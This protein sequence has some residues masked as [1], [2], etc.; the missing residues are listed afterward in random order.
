MDAVTDGLIVCDA[1]GRVE[2]LNAAAAKMFGYYPDELMGQKTCRL[3]P[4]LDCKV[5]NEGSGVTAIH[6]DGRAFKVT[7]GIRKRRS[8]TEGIFGAG[9]VVTVRDAL[10]SGQNAPIALGQEVASEQYFQAAVQFANDA[11]ITKNLDGIIVSWNASAERLYGHSAREAIGQHV[12]LIVPERL[13]GE[14]R[15]ELKQLRDGADIRDYETVRLN[16][17]NEEFR[18]SLNVSPIKARDGR[19]IGV[20]SIAREF[21]QRQ[22]AE[23]R[24]MQAIMDTVLDGLV[25]IDETG[26][27]QSFNPAATRLFGYQEAEVIG[28]NV[29]VLMPEPYRSE[30]DNYIASFL[31]TG[32]ARVI[33]IGREV[34]ARR[35]D[36][37]VF[38][39]DLGVAQTTLD[40]RRIFV[41]VLRDISQRKA[42]EER[43]IEQTNRLKAVMNT[44][45][46]GLI[47]IDESGTIRPF[48]PAAAKIFGYA[49]EEVTGRNVNMLMP[50]PY[51]S[52]HDG[53]LRNHLS[54]GRAK[55]IG[56]GREIFGRRKD[57]STFPAE[58]GVNE[59]VIGGQRMFVGTIR[60]ISARKA[61]EAQINDFVEKLQ[62]SNQDLDEFAYIASHDL[63]ELLRGLSNNAVFLEEDYRDRLDEG[64]QKR[65]A[66][67]VYLSDRL[68][69]LVNDLLYY[70]RLGRQDLAIQDTDLNG[71]VQDIE[72]LMAATLV[73]RNVEIKIVGRLPTI[74]CDKTRVTE[75]LRNLIVNAVKYNDKSKKII[76][77]GCREP[78]AR[79]GRGAPIFYVKDNGIGIAE[80]FHEDIFRIFKRLN[81]EDDATKGTGSGLTFVRK[82]VER[83][84]G[85]IWIESVLGD[86]TTFY[87]TLSPPEG[88]DVSE[89]ASP[90]SA[91]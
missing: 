23:A 9:F 25:T 85:R 57:G 41:G 65:L 76:E 48:N 51:H 55:M 67:M 2:G 24:R 53:Y 79:E 69:R 71:V 14:I 35:K 75:L 16:K 5:C 37:S 70:S 47:T 19:V 49:P 11:I 90:Q 31:K 78:V 4:E 30:H 56:I 60:D 73:E 36:G 87:F 17:A 34:M 74:T 91:A 26:T 52:A 88:G 7:V 3:L 68:E 59:T 84:G 39:A 8:R 89:R 46:D 77:I 43:L 32:E 12:D 10:Q 18:I 29:R 66:R 72:A 22:Q 15:R 63:K 20:S 44:V 27:I 6:K 21:A 1:D 64:A 81:V 80:R 83:H 40:G 82:I 42:D 33:G 58:L 38:P 50:E 13:R 62:R 45:L 54:T 28:K 61:A 86:G